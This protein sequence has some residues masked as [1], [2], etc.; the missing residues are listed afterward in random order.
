MIDA[1]W[2]E[3]YPVAIE[4]KLESKPVLAVY[5]SRIPSLNRLTA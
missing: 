4:Q 3:T 2:T 1:L 5:K